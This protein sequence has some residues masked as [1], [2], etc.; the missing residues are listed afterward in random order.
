MNDSVQ[1]KLSTSALAKTLDIP[2]QQLFGTLRDCGWIRKIE[3]GWVLTAKGEFEGGE[4]IHSKRYGRYIVWPE[5]LLEHQLLRGIE[6]N[7]LLNSAQ[8]ARKY[9]ISAR[10]V[11]RLLGDIGLLHRTFN[12]WE[13]TRDGEQLGGVAIDNDN[14][15]ITWPESLLENDIVIAQFE[16]L[17]R[18]HQ[19]SD[20]RESDQPEADLFT[21]DLLSGLSEFEARD[22]HRF[23]SRH[24]M[25]VCDWL[26]FAGVA[27]ACNYRLPL[28]L[29]SKSSLSSKPSSS[30]HSLSSKHSAMQEHRADFWL[31]A[32]HVFI[33]VSGDEKEAAD[34]A[35]AMERVELYRNNQWKFVE[36]RAEHFEHLDDYLT[37]ALRELGVDIL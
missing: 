33:E 19:V 5:T 37:R 8:I 12:G 14:G 18:V 29:A 4:Y 27:H 35:S 10:E 17:Q 25:V 30:K 32:S 1:Q 21:E 20:T 22:G 15:D 3:D 23:P 6:S 36:V 24:L 7:R 34:I 16:Y 2:L 11:R 28:S 31:P 9:Q 13:L 26:Y